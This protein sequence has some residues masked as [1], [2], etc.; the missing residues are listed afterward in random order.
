MRDKKSFE[1]AYSE[2]SNILILGSFPSPL[3]RQNGFY[4]GN[5]QNRFWPLMSKIA[6]CPLPETNSEKRAFL[7]NNKIA[8]WDIL[9]SC[10]IRGAADSTIC[11]EVASDILGLLGKT[12][13]ERIYCNGATAYKL[14]CK[15]FPECHVPCKQL[16]SSSPANA[17]WNLER[18]VAAWSEIIAP[19]TCERH[20]F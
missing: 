20:L 13:I 12:N 5:P 11:N 16:P 4:Y 6:R 17:A 1:P 14:F 15:F 19:Q 2:N 8:L 7:I 9:E 3:S 18:L 10:D